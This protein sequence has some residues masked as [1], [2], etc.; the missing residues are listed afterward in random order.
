MGD[1]GFRG[2]SW[3]CTFFIKDN[4][5]NKMCHG[6]EIMNYVGPQLYHSDKL[7]KIIELV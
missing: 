6:C 4:Q 3:K 1:L 2:F 5:F 7:A